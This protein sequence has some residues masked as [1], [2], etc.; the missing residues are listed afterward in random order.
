M[1]FG[2][3]LKILTSAC[4]RTSQGEQNGP[5]CIFKAPSS[6]EYLTGPVNHKIIMTSISVKTLTDY[7]PWFLGRI[8]FI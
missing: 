1:V 8:I 4:K 2:K 3:K 6:E 7:S 5:N